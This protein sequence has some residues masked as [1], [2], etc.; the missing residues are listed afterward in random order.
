MFYKNRLNIVLVR[1]LLLGSC[2]FALLVFL[3]VV[4]CCGF[5]FGGVVCRQ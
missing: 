3:S 4:V 2:L 1:G 5:W